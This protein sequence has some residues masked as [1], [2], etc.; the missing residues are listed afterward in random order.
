MIRQLGTGCL[1]MSLL[2]AMVACTTWP[3][4][5]PPADSGA[6]GSLL[7]WP[8]DSVV[9]PREAG[10]GNGLLRWPD[11]PAAE[12]PESRGQADRSPEAEADVVAVAESVKGRPYELGAEGPD[13][14]DCSGLVHYA[15]AQAGYQ[16]PRTTEEQFRAA[17]PVARSE[18]EPG[19]LIF[20]AVDGLNV[21]HVGIYGGDGRFLHA[22]SPGS[23]VSWADLDDD[24]WAGRF[25]GVGRLR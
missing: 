5:E 25:A 19:D 10:A 4:S 6:G 24:Y 14:F 16:V 2:L 17:R 9:E 21:S 7:S 11:G 12:A 13:R 18:K 23:E 22:P 20:F 15:Y 8:E 3:D 1:L